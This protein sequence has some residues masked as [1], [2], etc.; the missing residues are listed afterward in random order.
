VL[1]CK[2]V[3]LSTLLGIEADNRVEDGDHDIVLKGDVTLALDILPFGYDAM[4]VMDDITP[5]VAIDILLHTFTGTTDVIEVVPCLLAP[6][7]EV[8][9]NTAALPDGYVRRAD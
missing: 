4:L 1:D 2:T 6:Q 7:L 9:V 8:I 3:R 5:L